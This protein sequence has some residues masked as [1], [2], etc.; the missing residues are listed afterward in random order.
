MWLV[1]SCNYIPYEGYGLPDIFGLF[2]TH[3]AGMAFVEQAIVNIDYKPFYYNWHNHM[4]TREGEITASTY[5]RGNG[6][7]Y[8]D[9]WFVEKVEMN[10]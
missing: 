4:Q 3:E 1:Y 10:A 8:G 7:M 5:Y 2:P 6:G 9:E